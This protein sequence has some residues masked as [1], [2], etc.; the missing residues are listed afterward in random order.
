[1]IC[2]FCGHECK[3]DGHQSDGTQR[4]RCPHCLK[5]QQATYQYKAYSLDTN[6]Q[7]AS[8]TKIDEGIRDTTKFLKMSTTTLLKRILYNYESG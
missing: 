8:L 2:K 1:M 6:S 7:I 4:Y 3:K 5:R